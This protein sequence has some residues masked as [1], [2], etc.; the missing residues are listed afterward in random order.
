M[1]LHVGLCA[2]TSEHPNILFIAVDD[3][4]PELGAYGVEE[5]ISP[6]IDRL[7]S[8]G[9]LFS[10]AY[11]QVPVCGASRASLMTGLYP[12]PDRFVTYH[13]RADEDAPG[14]VDLPGWLKK[15]GYQT[16]SHGKIYHNRDDNKPSWDEIDRTKNFRV[17]LL[18]ENANLPNGKQPA[19]E[20]ADV[21]D[22]AYPTG[23]MT[24]RII[25]D[26]RQAKKDGTPFFIAAGYTKPHLPFNAPKK[27]WDL[28]DHESIELADNPFAPKG[29]PRQ[30][31]HQWQELRNGYGG[32]PKSGP[33][34]DELA[35]TLIHGYRA[36]VSYTDAMIGQVLAELDRLEMRENTIVILWGDHGWQLGEHSLWCKHALF[37]TSLNAPLI[38][39]A[40]GMK[41]EQRTSSLVEFVDIFPTLCELAGLKMPGH[42]QGTSLVPLLK[43]DE[44][45]LKRAAFSR[46]HGGEAV[47]TER[48]LY[49]EWSG[50][51][52]MLYDQ[53]IDPDQNI[54]VAENSEYKEVVAK[55][56][57]VLKAHRTEV[58]NS[59]PLLEISAKEKGSVNQAP[60]WKRGT[61]K[62]KDATVGE[63]YVSYVNWAA[64]DKEEDALEY[65]LLSGPDWLSMTNS[66][67]GKVEGTPSAEDLGTNEFVVSVSD[68]QNSPVTANLKIAVIPAN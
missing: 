2:E 48:F 67:Y 38:I 63:D 40:P 1:L 7:A 58:K 64:T 33:L 37:D 22:N 29:A 5:V 35:R 59:D 50:G 18:P 8:Q 14:I 51:A 41:E 11:C 62:L 3:L 44:L 23:Q 46:Y 68:G 20:S 13:S 4:R 28:Y 42:L 21:P 31:I 45:V 49:A 54:N 61:F 10:Q 60:K 56:S 9:T 43:N 16:I 36:A 25:D 66:K 12:T 32:I 39:S 6:N 57:A 30:A 26:L 17:Y 65:A 34:P 53:S 24:V 52:R 19:Y 27:Y 47:R 15:Y 55:L